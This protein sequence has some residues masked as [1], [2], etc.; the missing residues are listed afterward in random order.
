MYL[1]ILVSQRGTREAK[2]F[3]RFAYF[4]CYLIPIGITVWLK[5]T[6]RVGYS[7]FESTGWCGTVFVHLNKKREIFA[8]VFGYNLWIFLTFVLVPVLSI[9]AHMYIRDEV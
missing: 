9:S 1:Y 2:I 7:P 5:F 8:S 6:G 3:V 4:F